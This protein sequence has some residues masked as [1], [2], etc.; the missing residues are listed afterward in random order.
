MPEIVGVRFQRAGRMVYFDPQGLDLAVN[1]P[2]V[3]ETEEG[4][5]VGRVVVA[6]RQ[7]IYHEVPGPL[8]PLLRKATP[9]D[10]TSLSLS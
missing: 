9:D 2:V 10:L 7:V 1:D 5:H 8:P 3:V 6:P 4:L